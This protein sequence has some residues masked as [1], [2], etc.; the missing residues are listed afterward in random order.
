MTNSDGEY[1][2]EMLDTLNLCLSNTG[3]PIRRTNPNENIS[4][5]DLVICTPSLASSMLWS[6][7]QYSF[8]SDHFSLIISA[9][10]KNK[11]DMYYSKV[12]IKTNYMTLIGIHL[13]LWLNVKFLNS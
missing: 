8:G 13:K 3:A 4:V 10:I 2:L 12:S 7:F 1:L 5:V 9:P 6:P 11:T